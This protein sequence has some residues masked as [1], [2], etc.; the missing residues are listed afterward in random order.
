M[1]SWFIYHFKWYWLIFTPLQPPYFA[2]RCPV[3]RVGF[4][5]SVCDKASVLLL[6]LLLCSITSVSMLTTC[7]AHTLLGYF[8]TWKAHSYAPTPYSKY[9]LIKD[10]QK[11]MRFFCLLLFWLTWYTFVCLL[12]PCAVWCHSAQVWNIIP[13]FIFSCLIGCRGG[14]LA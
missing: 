9:F 8:V 2:W 7:N 3:V 11:P 4:T 6:L 13:I 1:Q 14:D 5:L 10:K 12:V